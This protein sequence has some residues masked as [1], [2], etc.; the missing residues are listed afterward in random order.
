MKIKSLLIAAILL[1]SFT[2]CVTA[3]D[4]TVKAGA[5]EQSVAA[6]KGKPFSVQIDS[7]LSTGHSWKLVSLPAP[8]KI[9]R[10]DVKTEETNKAGGIDIQEFVFSSS[11][12]GEFTLT[13]IYAAHWKEKPKTIKTS[14]VRVKVE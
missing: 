4:V 11:E 13:F 7:Q 5:G 3:P 14:T 1:V 8:F 10:E 6:K 9:I 2:S 12:S